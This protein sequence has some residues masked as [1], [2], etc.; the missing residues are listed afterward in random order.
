MERLRAGDHFGTVTKSRHLAGLILTESN[1][2]SGAKTPVHAHETASF[3][4]VISGSY[5]EH[6]NVRSF[7]CSRG[8]VLFRAS[9]EQHHDHISAH[10]ARCFMIDLPHEWQRQMNDA[11]GNVSISRQFKPVVDFLPQFRRELAMNDSATSIAI[12]ALTLE[13]ICNVVRE[14]KQTNVGPLWLTRLRDRLDAEFIR[15]VTLAELAHDSGHH[16]AHV[17]R[18]FRQFYGCSIGEYVRKCRVRHTC[19]QLRRGE[20]FSTVA[21]NSGF[22][23]Q[24]H[25]SRVFRAMMG[26]TP[27]QYLSLCRKS[28]TKT[29]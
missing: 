11:G 4:M 5:V 8:R 19:E 22:S 27:S 3:T 6:F 24:A 13:L 25:F 17:A 16:P 20:S 12:Q 21:L 10:G 28:K 1:Y 18:A 7:E 29:H 9:G 26:V 14:Q 2:G 15:K 23:D